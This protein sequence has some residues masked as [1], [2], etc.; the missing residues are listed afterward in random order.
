MTSC[1]IITGLPPTAFAVSPLSLAFAR[2]LPQK[3]SWGSIAFTKGGKNWIATKNFVFL[4]MTVIAETKV[5]LWLG[6]PP[7]YS[8]PQGRALGDNHPNNKK[9]RFL[10]FYSTS[11]HV[12]AFFVGFAH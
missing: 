4:A 1:F 5:L 9:L 10:L 8:L 7:F 6:H 12:E 2:Q 11:F 3:L